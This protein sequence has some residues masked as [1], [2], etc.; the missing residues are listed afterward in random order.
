[1]QTTRIRQLPH[2]RA[3][4]SFGDD[5]RVSG[6]LYRP[7]GFGII[8]P[9]CRGLRKDTRELRPMGRGKSAWSSACSCRRFRM[10]FLSPDL[11][12]LSDRVG[13]R[14]ILLW[15]CLPRR[16]LVVR[17]GGGLDPATQSGLVLL[18]FLSLA[19]AGIAS[20]TISPLRP[21]S[22]IRPHPKNANGMASSWRRVR[23]R[24]HVRALIGYGCLVLSGGE[25]TY[26]GYGVSHVGNR[27]DSRTWPA[28]RHACHG[29]IGARRKLLDWS[30]V[31]LRCGIPRSRQS[32]WFSSWRVSASGLR[33]DAAL[34]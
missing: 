22:P 21:S 32:S 13:R 5:D 27:V 17:L 10:Q 18:L 26:I 16:L 25:L 4:Q 6:R 28:A 12:R 9:C 34:F 20:A 31:G 8:L 14:P 23:Y 24:L 19:S 1:M 29:G 11:G 33:S 3:A 7:A 2:R 15:D 30:A